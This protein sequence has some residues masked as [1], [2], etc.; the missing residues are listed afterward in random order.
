M[1]KCAGRA[2]KDLL[3][4]NY[5]NCLEMN[6]MPLLFTKSEDELNESDVI[7][8]HINY[9]Y[10]KNLKQFKRFTFLRDPLERTISQYNHF[11]TM[12]TSVEEAE[13]L[14]LNKYSFLDFVKTN[15]PNLALWVNI[16]TV[17]MGD[18][19]SPVYNVREYLKR[20]I[21]NLNHI[22]FV[23]IY[24]QMDKSVERFKKRFGLK[25]DLNIVGKTPNK[26][27]VTITDKEKKIAKKY[28]IPD[29]ILYNMARGKI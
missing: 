29:Y 14:K 2:V 12:K 6:N 21:K 19:H 26:N 23:G 25:G 18:D 27:K 7:H 28:L 11:M 15:N 16:Y 13:I 22:D 4:Q 10:V 9:E 5:E 17:Q 3:H 1:P 20:A 8:G 24:E